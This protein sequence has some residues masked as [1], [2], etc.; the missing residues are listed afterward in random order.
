MRAKNPE[1]QLAVEERDAQTNGRHTVAMRAAPPLNQAAEAE[2][3]EVAAHLRG[4]IRATEERG[5]AGSK[6]TMAKTDG[7]MSKAAQRLTQR[8][9][10]RITEPQRG[11]P[12]APEMKR[13]L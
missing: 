10:A 8:L 2:A 6:I 9:D 12:N 1:V 7:Y 13:T 4:G 5:D 3:S 11:D